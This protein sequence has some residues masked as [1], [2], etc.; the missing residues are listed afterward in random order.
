METWQTTGFTASTVTSN[1][2]L[3]RVTTALTVGDEALSTTK[4]DEGR[5]FPLVLVTWADA[6]AGDGGWL[7]L[8][9]YEDD[10][11]VLVETL[12]FLVPADSPGG[13]K[14]HVTLWQS[15]HGGEGIHPFHIPT[16]MVRNMTTLT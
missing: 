2:V 13:K 9:N 7:E 14:N 8:D 5:P 3:P 12:G 6:H 16:G 15:Y 11:E 4:T 1:G 10:G